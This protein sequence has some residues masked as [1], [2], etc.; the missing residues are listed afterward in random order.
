MVSGKCSS[1]HLGTECTTTSYSCANCRLNQRTSHKS[2]AECRKERNIIQAKISFT[3]ARQDSIGRT[4]FQIHCC[5][6]NFKINC[7][8]FSNKI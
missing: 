3:E 6:Q 7:L 1:N 2:C 8:Q 4:I 5:I